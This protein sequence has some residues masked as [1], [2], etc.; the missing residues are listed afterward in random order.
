MRYVYWTILALNVTLMIAA[1]VR[2]SAN[3]GVNLFGIAVMA[4]VLFMEADTRKRKKRLDELRAEN[5]RIFNE[6]FK[7]F[8]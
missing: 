1:L 3:W 8:R 2:G 5:N 6:R 4:I 7:D